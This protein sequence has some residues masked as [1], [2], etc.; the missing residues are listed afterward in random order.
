M[1]SSEVSKGT[2]MKLPTDFC[3][4]MGGEQ[5][6][7]RPFITSSD[8]VLESTRVS[9]PGWQLSC[10]FDKLNEAIDVVAQLTEAAEQMAGKGAKEMAMAEAFS[11]T[12]GYMAAFIHHL[13]VDRNAP[14]DALE[15]AASGANDL[16]PAEM[17]ALRLLARKFGSRTN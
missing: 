16:A 6:A 4:S 12:F 5:R 15:R 2:R 1:V 10:S 17:D 7:P 11:A 9:Q 8:P 14:G 3:D 13:A